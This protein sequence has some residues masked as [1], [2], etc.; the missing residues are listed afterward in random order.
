M[1]DDTNS[2]MFEIR[3]IVAIF[4]TNSAKRSNFENKKNHVGISNK[5]IEQCLDPRDHI[6]VQNRILNLRFFWSDSND[7][8]ICILQ[9][10]LL[11]KIF[12]RVFGDI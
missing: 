8:I 6:P 1:K 9:V 7:N 4:V 10:L 5:V 11:H 3:A 2:P 12:W